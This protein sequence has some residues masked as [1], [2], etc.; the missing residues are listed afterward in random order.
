MCGRFTQIFDAHSLQRLR[1]FLLGAAHF[2]DELIDQLAAIPGSYNIAPTQHA[3]IIHGGHDTRSLGAC[4]A[5]FGLIPSWAW[6][7][8]I[9]AK[10]I[11]ARAE[12]IREKPAFRGLIGSR[13]AILPVSGFYEWQPLP[14]Q[15]GQKK[16]PKQPWYIR[17]ADEDPMLLACVWDTWLDP[18]AAGGWGGSPVDS[19]AIITTAANA[20][21]ED[22]HHRMPVILGPES[23]PAWLDREAPARSVDALLRPAAEGVLAMHRVSSRVNAPSNDD[24]SLIEPDSSAGPATLWG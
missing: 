6:E 12:T 13:R 3:A 1:A 11:N 5:H 14:P 7:R 21:L 8:S 16:P 23:L 22:K 10:M 24:P 15:L 18:H 9:S 17:R 19:F 20:Q 4:N 2:D